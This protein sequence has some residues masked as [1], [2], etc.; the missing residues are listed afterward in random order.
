M[1]NILFADGDSLAG[2]QTWPSEDE[3]KGDMRDLGIDDPMAGRS[4]RI[5][6][7]DIPMGMSD[8][9]ADWFVDEDGDVEWDED[10]EAAGDSDDEDINGDMDEDERPDY[11]VLKANSMLGEDRV[12]RKD[13]SSAYKYEEDD[14]NMMDDDFSIPG[15]VLAGITPAQGLEEK[16]LQRCED[17]VEVITLKFST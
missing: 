2:E 11:D 10:E 15:S 9:Q 13:Q 7:V 5:I 3:M 8:Y 12:E 6:P 1:D 16:R 4:R 14:D 17:D